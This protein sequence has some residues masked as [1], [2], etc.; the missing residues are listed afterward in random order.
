MA[1][2]IAY[3]I[4]G[5]GQTFKT[6]TVMECRISVCGLLGIQIVNLII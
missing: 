1:H 4:N 5:I 2:L 6:W 3:L